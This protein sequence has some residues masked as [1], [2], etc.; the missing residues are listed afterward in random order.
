MHHPTCRKQCEPSK[1]KTSAPSERSLCALLVRVTRVV[2]VRDVTWGLGGREPLLEGRD[3]NHAAGTADVILADRHEDR[4]FHAGVLAGGPG[5]LE[6]GVQS[7][8]RQGHR[9]RAFGDFEGLAEDQLLRK[10]TPRILHAVQL[11]ERVADVVR[12]AVEGP[13]LGAV[14]ELEVI[15]GVACRSAQEAADVEH[16]VVVLDLDVQEGVTVEPIGEDDEAEAGG[17]ARHDEAL[18]AHLVLD[19][20][21]GHSGK[22][23]VVEILGADLDGALVL[24][25][26]HRH[27]ARP[28][29]P[30]STSSLA[31]ATVDQGTSACRFNKDKVTL[32][33]QGDVGSVPSLRMRIENNVGAISR[34][35]SDFVLQCNPD[36]DVAIDAREKRDVQLSGGA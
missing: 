23:R 30:V 16:V 27:R 31:E 28:R 21:V 29:G 33:G 5:H 18:L 22:G 19:V 35:I 13:E 3:I 9:G 11:R 10:D 12:V 26:A 20:N 24:R 8:P 32:L 17:L 2:V 15:L 6:A 14:A 4:A 1:S 25:A 36:E 34:W 7:W